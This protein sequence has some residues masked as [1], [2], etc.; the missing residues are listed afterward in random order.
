MRFVTVACK[1]PNGIVLQLYKPKEVRQENRGTV[2]IEIQYLADGDSFTVDGPAAPRGQQHN[3]IIVGG[4]ALTSNVPKDFW[5]E[6][7][8]ANKDTYLV[9]SSEIAGFARRADAIAWC[10]EHKSVTSGFEPLNPH[11]DPRAPKPLGAGNTEPVV[12]AESAAA[13]FLASSEAEAV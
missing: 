13:R 6:W 11:G 3:K 12:D 4:F 1:H 8:D 5:D 7:Y 2:I 9:R 10:R